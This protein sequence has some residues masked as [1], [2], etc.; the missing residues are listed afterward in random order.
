MVL[1]MDTSYKWQEKGATLTDDT[2]IKEYGITFEELKKACDEGKM[3]FR[4]TTIYGNPSWRFLRHEIEGL[5]A[6]NYGLEHLKRLKYQ[7]ELKQTEKDIKKLNKQITQLQKRKFQL[8][9]LLK[10]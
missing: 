4:Y 8:E 5:I 2:A 7:N 9:E 1:K 10:N 6:E 3:Q